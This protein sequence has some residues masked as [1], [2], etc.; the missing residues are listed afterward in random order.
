MS[1]LRK[2]FG[3]T[4][5]RGREYKLLKELN[6]DEKTE[7][8]QRKEDEKLNQ[9]KQNSEFRDRVVSET[10]K[11]L[12]IY[13]SPDG[14]PRPP[15]IIF[16]ADEKPKT[17]Y[18]NQYWEMDQQYRLD[19]ALDEPDINDRDFDAFSDSMDAMDD[20]QDCGCYYDPDDDRD[21]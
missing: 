14:Y 2:L 17:D 15:E 8:T 9:K 1:L 20:R 13:Y 21:L 5:A 7:D 3:K 10:E 18:A 12:D 11:Q 6:L 4:S 16:Q 19:E